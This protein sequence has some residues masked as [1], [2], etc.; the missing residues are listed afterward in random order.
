[1]YD[2]TGK[3]IR[4]IEN[5]KVSEIEIERGN[6]SK[7]IYFFKLHGKMVIYGKMLVE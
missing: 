1:M 2:A 4:T 5:V 7:G 3:I 6:L